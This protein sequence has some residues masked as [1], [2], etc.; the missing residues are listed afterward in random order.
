MTQPRRYGASDPGV[1]E[2]L[3]QLLQEVGHRAQRTVQSEAVAA[4]IDRLEA[5]VAAETYDAV[6]R[7]QF[8]RFA[9]AARVATVE[10]RWL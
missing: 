7:E 10:H 8:E 4:Q 5:S 2:R 1:V 6:E 3:H 9:E